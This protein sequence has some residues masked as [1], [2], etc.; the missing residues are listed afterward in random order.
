MTNNFNVFLGQTV[1]FVFTI[2][3][4]DGLIVNLLPASA[5][6]VVLKPANG[7]RIIIAAPDLSDAALGI[8]SYTTLPTDLT[9]IGRWRA[10]CIVNDGALEYPSSIIQFTVAGRV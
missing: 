2:R 8:V 5:V 3:N 9:T 7:A 10:Q 1:Q 6:T 4:E